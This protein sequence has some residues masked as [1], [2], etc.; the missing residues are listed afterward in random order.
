MD[1]KY[2]V[3][4]EHLQDE[5]GNGYNFKKVVELA[6]KNKLELTDEDFKRFL[7]LA[8]NDK[9]VKWIMNIMSTY[10]IS[11]IDTLISYI[12]W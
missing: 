6:N 4:Y 12:T 10:D 3:Q 5:L 11:F 8:E 9:D 2:D 7:K 1:I